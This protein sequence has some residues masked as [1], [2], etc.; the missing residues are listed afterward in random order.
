MKTS[1]L[2]FSLLFVLFFNI[3]ALSQTFEQLG[4]P[5]G[6]SIQSM[7]IDSATGNLYAGTQGAGI[8]MTTNQGDLWTAVNTGISCSGGELLISA[9]SIDPENNQKLLAGEN[10]CRRIYRTTDGGLHWL[11]TSFA[12]DGAIR[13]IVY[14]KQELNQQKIKR[15]FALTGAGAYYSADEGSNWTEISGLMNMEC[16]FMAADPD[17]QRTFY[18]E[19]EKSL[20]R[21]TDFGVTWTTLARPDSDY[22]INSMVFESGA[23]SRIYACTWSGV[24]ISTDQGSSWKS[25]TSQWQIND[26]FCNLQMTTGKSIYISVSGR[27]TFKLSSILPSPKWESTGNYGIIDRNFEQGGRTFITDPRPNKNYFYL[28]SINGGIFVSTNGGANW[29]SKNN[30]LLNSY[31]RCITLDPLHPDTLY[32]G[33]NSTGIFKSTNGGKAWFNISDGLNFPESEGFCEI[34]SI[35][36][37]YV[38]S[39]IIY[40]SVI[41]Q[42]DGYGLYRS[43]DGG[44]TWS[45]NSFSNMMSLH[46][47]H[48]IFDIAIDPVNSSIVYAAAEGNIFKSTDRGSNWI[49]S[50]TGLVGTGSVWKIKINPQDTKI[51]YAVSSSNPY[52]TPAAPGGVWKS[53]DAGNSWNKT[54]L[55]GSD[56]QAYSITI[57]EKNPNIIY[58]SLENRY[59]FSSSDGGSTWRNDSTGLYN[60]SSGI[61]IDI[62][63]D[64]RNTSLLYCS[65]YYQ[66]IFKSK[67]GGKSW[68][69]I[70]GTT[71]KVRPQ[72]FGYNSLNVGLFYLGSYGGGVYKMSDPNM[73]IAKDT[74]NFGNTAANV[75]KDSTIKITSYGFGSLSITKAYISPVSGD[76]SIIS[77]AESDVLKPGYSKEIKIRFL[78]SSAGIKSANL[79]I[80]SNDAD[81]NPYNIILKGNVIQDQTPPAITHTPIT[82][83][84]LNT[85]LKISFTLTDALSNL[86]SASVYY[87]TSNSDKQ[88]NNKLDA[89]IT[90]NSKTGNYEITI[91]GSAIK[92]DGLDYKITGSD[93]YDNSKTFID[94]ATNLDYVSVPVNIPANNIS[95]PATYAGSSVSAY[96]I[97]SIPFKF[98]VRTASS[99]FGSSGDYKKSWRF[100]VYDGTNWLDGEGT[101]LEIGKGYFLITTGSQTV[102]FTSS[103]VSSKISDYQVTGIPLVSGW[104]LIGNPFS[105]NIPLSCLSLANGK[106]L[107]SYAYTGSWIPDQP[108]QAWSG[109][110]VYSSEQTS[111]KI[112][113]SNTLLKKPT[114]EN[115]IL[116]VAGVKV[117]DDESSDNYN[118][119]GEIKNNIPDDDINRMEPPKF[120]G[121]IRCYF[122]SQNYQ[123]AGEYKIINRNGASWNLVIDG[124]RNK[125]IKLEFENLQNIPSGYEKYLIDMDRDIQYN[126]SDINTI[127]TTGGLG[128]RLFKLLIGTKEYIKINNINNIPGKYSLSQNYPNPFNPSTSILF[129]LPAD[130]HIKITLYD[131][132]GRVVKE[133]LNEERRAG[134]SEVII[135]GTNLAS[136]AYFYSLQVSGKNSFKEFKKMILIK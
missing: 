93:I 83:A 77:G 34:F 59:I 91:P 107:Q 58:T 106:S 101:Q 123:L 119:F 128:Q 31:V 43:T 55:T 37:D 95:S 94:P 69:Q 121:I 44:T 5:F 12:S 65:D 3:P 82:S 116:W 40:A 86:K 21:T 52:N 20:V 114:T 111:L 11:S 135:D 115:N 8:F 122:K 32:C 14:L 54:S 99:L 28:G 49:Q 132:Y 50:S 33:T 29:T 64:P 36:C 79:F 57:N 45:A 61:I 113:F 131:S 70:S 134:Y 67:D 98:S 109:L 88:F 81:R 22:H 129:G 68:N 124:E 56:A 9:I 24:F 7:A 26:G 105:F 66:G 117:S 96:R 71:M 110:A 127:R 39:Q 75:Q 80:E 76:F 84:N 112:N 38:N 97:F 120:D 15:I 30:G 125:V 126:L 74:L 90:S 41:G 63:V 118:F 62:Y 102:Q 35:A 103:S 2:A 48:Y 25:I 60:N 133:I 89:T 85:D 4:G 6:G 10:T 27:G 73:Y 51:L 100:R 92:V 1:F 46:G 16:F 19:T 23:V 78:S 87:K 136:G 108:L 13:Q 47:A 17:N 53:T 42:S 130:S 72:L 18:L 104:N